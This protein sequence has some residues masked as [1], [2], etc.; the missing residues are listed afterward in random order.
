MSNFDPD[1]FL[2][3]RAAPPPTPSVA[4]PAA[5]FDPDAFLAKTRP[6]GEEVIQEMHPAFSDKDRFVV[7]NFASG[8]DQALTYLQ[9]R[10]PNLELRVANGDQIQAREKG[11][12]TAYR[13]LDPDT[14]FFSKDMLRDA[15]D[16]VYDAFSGVGTGLATGAAGAAGAVGGVG[17]GAVPAAMAGGAAASAGFE[18]LKQALGDSLGIED[19]Y[20]A[21]NLAIAG[22][23]GAVSP[24][25]FGTG[26]TAGQV[27]KGALQ[28]KVGAEAAT[29]AQRGLV[30]RGVDAYGKPL[31]AKIGSAASG[32]SEDVLET[33]GR[34]AD[35]IKSMENDPKAVTN[36][37]TETGKM[38]GDKARKAEQQAWNT[39]SDAVKNTT[40]AV[41]LTPVVALKN[42]VIATAEAH[43]DEL[44]TK[45]NLDAAAA[46]KQALDDALSVDGAD[47]AETSAQAAARLSQ[48]LGTLAEHGS[49][50]P[51][52]MGVNTGLGGM[53][54]TEREIAIAARQ[55]KQELD[56]ALEAV[57]PEPALAARAR[58][59][60]IANLH[61]RAD[62]LI[63]TPKQA[64][65]S[66]RNADKTPN[67]TNAELLHE[68]DTTL[69]TDLIDRSKILDSFATLRRKTA[70]TVP[71]GS[72]G[73]TSTSRSIPLAAGG[74]AAGYYLGSSQGGEGRGT[75]VLG[76]FGGMA[77]GGFLGSPAM[78]RRAIEAG[79]MLR[80]A[81][82]AVG[83]M[84]PG[85]GSQVLQDKV[86][87][88]M[89]VK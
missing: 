5:G 30:G 55:L 4:A 35:K 64:F 24:L 47:V 27:A 8:Q 68:L 28:K 81:D 48:N 65:A 75:G 69:G 25:L 83:P 70:S 87:P 52:N 77:L 40:A 78:M 13:V 63:R 66:L 32:V 21:T 62:E 44:G 37:V 73:A 26:A 22:G 33:F 60:E 36:F 17:V 46:L 71:L 59:G 86:S 45:T 41:D 39:Y 31:L 50:K 51:V 56:Q 18:G 9:K 88:W 67:I 11:K 38:I 74:G 61:R 43:A 80:K 76:G 20:D 29:A 12:E 89:G 72:G 42:Q 79:L 16:I 54:A 6:Q 1:A 19:N 2:A 85:F 7:K 57:L 49:L 82:Q 15:G 84:V 34:K 3:K 58:Y 10:H 23:A 53:S 14:G